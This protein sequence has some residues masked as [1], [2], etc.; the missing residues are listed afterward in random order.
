MRLSLVSGLVGLTVLAACATSVV[1]PDNHT[2]HAPV[3]QQQSDWARS[4]K[5][6]T[7]DIAISCPAHGIGD[8][9]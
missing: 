1:M 6:P 2:N 4:G 9:R 3:C 7:G 5:V 8:Y